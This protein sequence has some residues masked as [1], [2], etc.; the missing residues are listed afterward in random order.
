[1]A[2]ERQRPATDA[3]KTRCSEVAFTEPL[4]DAPENW[5]RFGHDFGVVRLPSNF[6]AATGSFP[7]ECEL[8]NILRMGQRPWIFP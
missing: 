8:A 6:M 2:V 7:A 4:L 1:M 3:I 5:G